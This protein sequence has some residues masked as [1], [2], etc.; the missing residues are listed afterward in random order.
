MEEAGTGGGELAGEVKAPLMEELDHIQMD[1]FNE[2][3]DGLAP[4][5][6]H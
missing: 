5:N 2:F 1:E 3:C 6:D 4:N